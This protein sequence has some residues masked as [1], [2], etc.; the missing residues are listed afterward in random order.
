MFCSCKKVQNL[1]LK[2]IKL[3]IQQSKILFEKKN[4][5]KKKFDIYP[6]NKNKL[7]SNNQKFWKFSFVSVFS[8]IK[9]E[10]LGLP[11]WW[12]T[13]TFWLSFCNVSTYSEPENVSEFSRKCPEILKITELQTKPLR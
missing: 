13:V 3:T 10:D 9:C 5:Y 6:K 4:S 1:D 2:P 8:A 12:A 7:Y 11:S